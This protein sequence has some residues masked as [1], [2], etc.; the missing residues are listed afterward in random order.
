MIQNQSRPFRLGTHQSVAYTATA[1]T[2]TNA[3]GSTTNF[4]RVIATTAA[5]VLI[6][7]NPTATT[8]AV[9]MPAGLPEYFV[10]APGMKASGIQVA[11]GGTLHVTELSG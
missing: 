4:V 9:Y 8:A 3:F 11:A 10:V 5:Y 7:N 1:G 2:V 6:G